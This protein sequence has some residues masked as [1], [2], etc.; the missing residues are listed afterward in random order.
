M[1]ENYNRFITATDTIRDLKSSLDAAS[2]SMP[3]LQQTSGV[4]FLPS[5]LS[6]G[7]NRNSP[8]SFECSHV[9]ASIAE[10]IE[11]CREAVRSK[12]QQRQNQVADLN[13]VQSLL[14]KLERCA[15]VGL[16]NQAKQLSRLVMWSS[17]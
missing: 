12:L 1:Y 16:R 10:E 4:M 3:K 13:E 7:V 8:S 17:I 14:M 5:R 2:P 6:H 11:Q 15:P 9:D